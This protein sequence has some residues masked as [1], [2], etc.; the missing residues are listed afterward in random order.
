MGIKAWTVVERCQASAALLWDVGLEKLLWEVGLQ[1]RIC[2]CFDAGL[3]TLPGTSRDLVW[4]FG[5]RSVCVGE[6]CRDIDGTCMLAS[7][8]PDV[9]RV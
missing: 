8:L 2:R 7:F 6:N 9:R 4:V 5:H 3:H 1:K